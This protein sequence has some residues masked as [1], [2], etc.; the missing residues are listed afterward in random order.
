[1]LIRIRGI[2]FERNSLKAILVLLTCVAMLAI[3]TDPISPNDMSRMATIQSLVESHSLIIDDTAFIKT[4][5][6]IYVNGHFYSEKPPMTSVVGAAIYLPLHALGF[7]LHAGSSLAYYLIT[8][9]TVKMLWL[10]ATIAFYY[11]LGFT[12]LDAPKRLIA[13]FALGFGSLFFSWSSVFNNHEFAGACL[14]IGF[15]FL[16]RAR[17]G[18]ARNWSL[19]AAAFFL[20][21]A[22]SVDAPTAIFYAVFLLYVLAEP[23]LR[24]SVAFYLV[25]LLVTVLPTLALNYA[26]HRSI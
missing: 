6:K 19:A 14:C 13:T 3:H 9:A 18:Q 1:M 25:P 2:V 20:S 21:F 7:Q 23:G 22:G 26:V 12:K 24:R 4:I 15:C 10:F 8:F 11:A 16:L 5:D 17:F